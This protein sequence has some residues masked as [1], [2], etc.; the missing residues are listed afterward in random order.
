M[1]FVK[2]HMSSGNE[3]NVSTFLYLQAWEPSLVQVTN[4]YFR[5]LP[6]LRLLKPKFS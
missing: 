4:C 3:T 2:A 6:A 5:R 1:E